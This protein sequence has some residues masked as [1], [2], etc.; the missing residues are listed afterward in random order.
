MNDNELWGN[1]AEEAPVSGKSNAPASNS[2]ELPAMP[3]APVHP[4]DGVPSMPTLPPPNAELIPDEIPSMPM[5]PPPNAELIPDE[6]PSMPTLPPP[7]P[8]FRRQ[9]QVRF[10]NAAYGCRSLRIFIKNKRA[11]NWLGYAALSSYCK[12]PVGYQTITVASP[13]GYIY[14]QKTLPFQREQP[15]TVAVINCAS[16]L[17]L[18]QIP[19]SCCPPKNGFSNFRVC[20]LARN[21]RPLD[22][23][24]QD[25]R[26]VYTDVQFKETTAFKRIRPGSYTFFFAETELTPMPLWMDIE[27]LDSTFWGARSSLPDTVASLYLNADSGVS[28]TVFLLSS[29][30]GKNEVQAI[31]TV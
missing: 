5:L 9:T 21:S 23:L 2:D 6:I 20:N 18:L 19:D 25:G 27:T 11:V 24:L 1:A 15:C 31:L 14:V 3:G 7:R 17:D 12:V 10:L 29:G 13:D 8:P 30:S 26:V 22:V 16:G 28:Y 4:P